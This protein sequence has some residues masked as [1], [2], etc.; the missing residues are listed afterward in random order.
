MCNIPNVTLGGKMSI[1][2]K[3]IH[4]NDIVVPAIE[5][6][7]NSDKI[8]MVIHGYGGNKEE[9]MGLSSYLYFN[10]VDSITIDLRGHGESTD[11][12]SIRVLDDINELLEKYGDNKKTIAI[13]HSLGGRLALLSKADLKIGISPA[14]SKTYSEQTKAMIKNFRSYRVIEESQE[15]NFE[16]LQ[17]LDEITMG[18]NLVLYGTRDI[19][20][21][22][23]ACEQLQGPGMRIEKIKDA[24][25]NDI[26]VNY[27][28][29]N[30]IAE[31]IHTAPGE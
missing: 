12:Y 4:V 11:D 6:S 29:F 18:N 15:I 30:I 3:T 16:I 25:H 8:A 1:Q 14:L 13:G 19:P 2:H 22:I 20:E 9:I 26:Y 28:V 10:G 31:F 17:Q 5:M 7:S 24:L 23:K 21:I 27:S